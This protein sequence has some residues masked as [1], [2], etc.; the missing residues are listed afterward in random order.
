MKLANG[1]SGLSLRQSFKNNFKQLLQAY[2]T[3]QLYSTYMVIPSELTS[4]IH[5]L[6]ETRVFRFVH[7]NFP[8]FGRFHPYHKLRRPL[9][10][11]EV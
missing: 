1:V 6:Q 9:G 4:L 10:R 2:G 3:S 5:F 8:L 7:L 11:V